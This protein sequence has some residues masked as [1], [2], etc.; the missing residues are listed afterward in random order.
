MTTTTVRTI[1]RRMEGFVPA[2]FN[3]DSERG[4]VT[5]TF[6]SEVTIQDVVQYLKS[7][8]ANHAFEPD[9]FELVDLTQ[10]M[11]SEVDFQAAMML[12]HEVDPFSRRARRAFVAPR[13]ATFRTIRMYQVARGDDGSIAVF[14]T[15]AEAKHWLDIEQSASG[16]PS[17]G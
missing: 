17:N 5:V 4:L 7:L 3:V 13:A 10:V 9:F 16:T 11:S 14:R 8:K 6:D 12:A 2:H 1:A 15:I